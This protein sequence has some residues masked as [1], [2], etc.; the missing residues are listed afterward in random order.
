M[1]YLQGYQN[2]QVQSI[3]GQEMLM[4][5][6][7]GREKIISVPDGMVNQKVKDMEEGKNESVYSI[8]IGGYFDG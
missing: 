2:I 7:E 4:I 6:Q 5:F 3:S 1:K 8:K